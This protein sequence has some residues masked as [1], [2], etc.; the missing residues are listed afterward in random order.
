MVIIIIYISY[1]EA[2][3][4]IH[5][6]TGILYSPFILGGGYGKVTAWEIT[7]SE[8]YIYNLLKNKFQSGLGS[9]G[10]GSQP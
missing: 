2:L 7:P 4:K 8:I 3:G 6:K 1:K 10:T 9:Q 5:W